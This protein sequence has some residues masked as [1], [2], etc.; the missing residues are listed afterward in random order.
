MT[1]DD[2]LSQLSILDMAGD[3]DFDPT[4]VVGDLREKVDAIRTVLA[5]L[6]NEHERLLHDAQELLD[7]ARAVKN[8]SERL[9]EYVRYSMETHGFEK[10]PG[11]LW[12]LQLQRAAPAL[13]TTAEANADMAVKF[14]DLVKR[15]V[16]YAWDKKAIKDAMAKGVN[17]EY[18]YLRESKSIQFPVRKGEK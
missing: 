1:L 14:P 7:S 2:L 18:G 4:Q 13:E 15:T 16:I 5:R 6:K 17:F 11:N 8:N 10:I 9:K 3:V 12:C